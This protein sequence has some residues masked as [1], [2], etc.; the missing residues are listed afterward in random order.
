MGPRESTAGDPASRSGLGCSGEAV[1]SGSYCRSQQRI[2]SARVS[3]RTQR[4]RG[5]GEVARDRG[6][7]SM[8][9]ESFREALCK[10]LF[11]SACAPWWHLWKAS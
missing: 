8:G 7:I 4:Q 11:L 3:L 9:R 10:D 5:S 2:E 1:A 6:K